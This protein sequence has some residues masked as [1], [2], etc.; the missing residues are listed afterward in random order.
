MPPCPGSA[1]LG[2]DW[3]AVARSIDERL[4]SLDMT[5]AELAIRAHVAPETIRELRNN[6]RPRRRNPRTLAAIS[7]ALGWDP[8]HL[9]RV[10]ESD[11]GVLESSRGATASDLDELRQAYADLADR[12][13]AIERRLAS[14]RPAPSP[15]ARL[16]LP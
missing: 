6:L 13:T 14:R 2:K 4:A 7:Q 1:A 11:G 10:L 16:A 9:A 3:D 12:V 8:G 5:Q 15:G